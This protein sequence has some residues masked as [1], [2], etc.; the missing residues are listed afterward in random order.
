MKETAPEAAEKNV[1]QL[2]DPRELLKATGVNDWLL[3]LPGWLYWVVG[4]AVVLFVVAVFDSTRTF[5]TKNL[6]AIYRWLKRRL[7]L[8]SLAAEMREKRRVRR[9]RRRGRLEASERRLRAMEILPYLDGPDAEK[10]LRKHAARPVSEAFY[11]KRQLGFNNMGTV[12]LNQEQQLFFSL[13]KQAELESNPIVWDG[14]C[15]WLL[16]DGS[17]VVETGDGDFEVGTKEQMT[18]AQSSFDSSI[19]EKM[20]ELIEEGWS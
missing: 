14:S 20:G 10:V 4:T 9:I 17:V 8:K 1:Q 18:V 5:V 15:L 3:T 12:V 19:E 16:D 7:F 11:D 2:A 13:L 6:S